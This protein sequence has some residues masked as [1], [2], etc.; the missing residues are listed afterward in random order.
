MCPLGDRRGGPPPGPP[1]RPGYDRLLGKDEMVNGTL[2]M[3]PPLPWWPPPPSPGGRG[4][5]RMSRGPSGALPALHRTSNRFVAGQSLGDDPEEEK[6]QKSFQ[7]ILNKITPDNFERLTTKVRAC[8]CVHALTL[9][10]AHF[11]RAFGGFYMF[12][13]VEARVS[14]RRGSRAPEQGHP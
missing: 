9:S 3:N 11:C 10:R 12:W 5:G 6:R 8:I 13:G 4:R 7:G 14:A 1:Q 2:Q